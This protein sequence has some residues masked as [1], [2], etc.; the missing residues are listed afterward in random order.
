MTT[1]RKIVAVLIAALALGLAGCGGDD[2]DALQET[3]ESAATQVDETVG[4]AVTEAEDA[5]GGACEDPPE[6]LEAACEAVDDLD[7]GGGDASEA[8]ND[9]EQALREDSDEALEDARDR[10]EEA[11]DNLESELDD[12]EGDARTGAERVIDALDDAIERIDARLDE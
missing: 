10:L 1:T 11:R 8:L 5:L 2:D 12:L 6:E 7:G 3:L 4:S 9:A